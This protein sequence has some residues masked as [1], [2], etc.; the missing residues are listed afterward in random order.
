MPR[1]SAI[2]SVTFA[3]GSMPPRPGFAPCDS[4]ISIALTGAPAHSSV[5]FS[6]EKS[7][8]SSR[9]PKYDVPIWKT[10]SP[11]LRWYGDSAP[12]PVSCRQPAIA[13]P[14]LSASMA[15]FESEPKLM[16][17]ML[18]TLAGRNACR[19][20]RGPPSTFADGRCTSSPACRAVGAPSPLNVRCLMIG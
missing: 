18:T 10:R 7:P 16:P 13:A 9:H 15:F 19:R 12:S 17:E 5:S 2:S 20:P 8:C 1:I 6:S 14:R 4:L 3:P 11:P